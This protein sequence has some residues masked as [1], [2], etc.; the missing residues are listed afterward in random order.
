MKLLHTLPLILTAC[1][2]SAA[3]AGGY[4]QE[5]RYDSHYDSHRVQPRR[6]HHGRQVEYIVVERPVYRAPRVVYREPMV[7]YREPVTVYL[8]RPDGYADVY[9]TRRRQHHPGYSRHQDGMSTGTGQ[10]LGAVAGGV[11]GSRFGQGN[12]RLATTA[13]G[14]VLGGVVGGELARD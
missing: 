10:I 1:I 2:S 7:V 3:L 12:G 4:W 11:I 9:Q 6:H 5:E 13:I 8:D 14:A